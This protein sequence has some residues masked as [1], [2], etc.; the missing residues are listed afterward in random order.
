ML[1]ITMILNVPF[2][3]NN[4][5]GNQCMQVAMQCAIKYFLNKEISLNTLDELSGRKANFWTYTSQIVSVLYD[6][7]LN[8]KFYSKED[9]KPYLE[10]EPFIKRHFGKDADKIIK[11]TDIPVVVRATEK[12]LQYNVFEKRILL[13]TEIEKH[14]EKGHI[15][16][17]L[18]DYNKIN[19]IEG[20]YQGHFVVVTGF[21]KENIYFHESGPK[22]PEPN[23]KVK[24]EFF[25][26][27]MDANG[28]DNDCVI[29]LGKR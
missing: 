4:G 8:L 26:E 2:Y 29:I 5:D 6:L 10:G 16:L 17:I 27:A 14:L 28:T 12:L 15:P 3:E 22:N 25:K 20:F 11:F 13:L 19:R 21:D 24:K 1:K 9:L 7:G 23:K 18:I